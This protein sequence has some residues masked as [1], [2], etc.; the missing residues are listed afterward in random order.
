M[1]YFTVTFDPGTTIFIAQINPFYWIYHFI[2]S[3]VDLSFSWLDAI[4]MILVI[5]LLIGMVFIARK[6]I[7]REKVLFT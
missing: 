6:S 5:G 2:L 4:Y 7:E 3:I 1:F